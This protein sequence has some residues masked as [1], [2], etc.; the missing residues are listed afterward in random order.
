MDYENVMREYLTLRKKVA[1][2]EKAVKAEV[3]G[4]KK[5]MA[6][7]ESQ[8]SEAAR[9]EGLSTVSTKV[10]TGYWTQ[11]ATCRTD[12]AE[13]FFEYV[14]KNQFW[15]LLDKRPSKKSVG[16]YV[17]SAGVPPPGVDFQRVAVFRIRENHDD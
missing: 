10:G 8:L 2:I 9:A 11:T 5:E 16:E 4:H 14:K 12:N 13:D 7:L 1:V 17:D 15:G 6:I 3:A